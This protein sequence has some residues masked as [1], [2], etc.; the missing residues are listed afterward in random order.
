MKTYLGDG[1]YAEWDGYQ[2]EL[3]TLDG[4]KVYLD[5]VVW[6]ALVLFLD[7]GVKEKHE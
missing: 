5:A 3:S 6:D 7:R 2:L 1:L 4:M